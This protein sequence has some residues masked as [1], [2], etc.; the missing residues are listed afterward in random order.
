MSVEEAYDA[1][2]IV[3]IGLLASLK[4]QIGSLDRVKRVVKTLGMVNATPDF[5]DQPL[6]INGFSDLI[7]VISGY[8]A[9]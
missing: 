1:A 4:V 6:V 7:G 2:R 3:G 5:K 8:S 9:N